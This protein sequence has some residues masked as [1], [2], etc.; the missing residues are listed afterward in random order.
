MSSD[1]KIIKKYMIFVDIYYTNIIHKITNIDE[2]IF[3]KMEI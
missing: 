2:N 3:D 1:R